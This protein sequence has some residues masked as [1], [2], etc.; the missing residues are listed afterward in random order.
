MWHDARNQVQQGRASPPA[1][2]TSRNRQ[3]PYYTGNPVEW[4]PDR[5]QG[6]LYI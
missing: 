4:G 1:T 6:Q 2:G 3:E 5:N